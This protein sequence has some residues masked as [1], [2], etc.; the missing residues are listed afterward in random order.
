MKY[1]ARHQALTFFTSNRFFPSAAGS[2]GVPVLDGRTAAFPFAAEG[3]GASG[4]S[5][6]AMVNLTPSRSRG[7]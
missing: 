7:S 1:S 3:V 5:T 6:S 2:L 4:I